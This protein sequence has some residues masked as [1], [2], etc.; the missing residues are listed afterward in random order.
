MI[1][2]GYRIVISQKTQDQYIGHLGCLLK[3]QRYIALGYSNS[4]GVISTVMSGMPELAA[5]V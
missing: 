1:R 4:I 3:L 2:A 5:S